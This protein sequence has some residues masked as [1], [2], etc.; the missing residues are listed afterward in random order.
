MK[1]Q[2]FWTA[3]QAVGANASALPTAKVPDPGPRRAAPVLARRARQCDLQSSE[4]ETT[5]A[6]HRC[7][8]AK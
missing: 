8:S 7:K 4:G 6:A 2:S 5:T 1:A 3:S